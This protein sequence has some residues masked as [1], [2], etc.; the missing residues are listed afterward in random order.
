MKYKNLP[1]KW[2]ILLPV[3]GIM[4]FTGIFYTLMSGNITRSIVAEENKR[5]MEHLSETIFAVVT[6]YMIS[7][8]FEENKARFLQHMNKMIP[9]SMI[10]SEKLDSQFSRKGA[11]D[12]A[13][14]PEEKEVLQSGKTAFL[15]EKIKGE[16]YLKGIFPY[17]NVTDYMGINCVGCHVQGAKDGDIL[18]ALEIGVPLTGVEAALLRSKLIIAGI[19]AALTLLTIFIIFFI[20]QT[21]VVKPLNPVV[22][23]V[24][25]ASKKDFSKVLTVLYKDE[26]GNLAESIN[27]MSG[28]LAGTMKNVASVSKDLSGN[29]DALKRAIEQSLEGAKQQAAQATQIATASEE[30]SQ[31]ITGIAQSGS[32]AADLSSEAMGAARKGKEVVQESVGKIES[33]GQSTR[34]LASMIE[35]LNASVTEIGNIIMVIKDIADQ[36][37][38]LA[39][40]AAIEAARAGEQGRGFAVVADEVRKLAERTTKATGEISQ[41]ISAVQED[42]RQTSE[43]MDN[44]LVYV[45]D[46]VTFMKNARESLEQ[47]VHSVQMTSDEVSQIAASVEEQSATAS[48]ITRNIEDI[49]VIA[50]KAKHS[51]E[52]LLSVFEKLNGFSKSLNGMV[53]EF[54]FLEKR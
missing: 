6:Q 12:Y 38:L 24:E 35:R 15:V 22:Q 18:G 41:R 43:S 27:V 42:S 11:E 45:N 1:I 20:V 34:E 32:K 7:D 29:A 51:T 21:F 10:R 8:K 53:E 44:S 23:V 2:K 33:A 50:Q 47:I 36:T 26:I 31:T 19:S 52:D 14:T 40:N 49:S 46:G 17:K 9:V 39:L 30:M 54:T 5:S 16:P 3:V 13:K 4:V 37:N 25:R 48:E 28:E